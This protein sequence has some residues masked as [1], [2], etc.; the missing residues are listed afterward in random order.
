MEEH[1]KIGEKRTRINAIVTVI[2]LEILHHNLS[3]VKEETLNKV[4]FKIEEIQYT[5]I[6]YIF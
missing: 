1:N 2:S 4:T 6:S 3:L 5:Y